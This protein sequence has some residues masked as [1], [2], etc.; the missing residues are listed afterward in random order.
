M[1][2]VRELE[3]LNSGI[4]IFFTAL[5]K[6]EFRS[7][8]FYLSSLIILSSSTSVIFSFD[9]DFSESNSLTVLQNCLFSAMSSCDLDWHS[10]FF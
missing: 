7:S 6:K 10:A 3:S 5:E 9:F 2:S 4:L 1:F 8:A